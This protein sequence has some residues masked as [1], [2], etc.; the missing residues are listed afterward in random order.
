MK[1]LKKYTIDELEQNYPTIARQDL[2]YYVGGSG[3]WSG[4]GSDYW[5][6]YG[7]GYGSGYGTGPF[8]NID[9]C[10][11]NNLQ[12]VVEQI[13][14][15][16]GFNPDIYTVMSHSDNNRTG[17]CEYGRD[18]N[19]NKYPTDIYI[20]PNHALYTY[21]NPYDI[22]L[23]MIHEQQHWDTPQDS[24]TGVYVENKYRYGQNEYE[25]Y[26]AQVMSEYFENATP[27]YKAEIIKEYLLNLDFAM[28][29]QKVQNFIDF[30]NTPGSYSLTGF[31]NSLNS[32]SVI[33]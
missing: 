6:G 31:V 23:V 24:G 16:L 15:V 25:A 11:G 26:R 5:A 30:L 1:K 27:A 17:W 32:F 29:E 33:K 28:V 13:A 21:C 7:S 2:Q 9:G 20:N 14:G 3:Y 19:G 22:A 10:D 12:S 4:Y 8:D 18:S